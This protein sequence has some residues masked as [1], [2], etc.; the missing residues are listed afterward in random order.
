MK[1]KVSN[2]AKRSFIAE[3]LRINVMTLLNWNSLEYGNF[4]FEQGLLYLE[5]YLSDYN[6]HIQ[7]EWV[8]KLSASPVFWTWWKNH[9]TLRDEQFFNEFSPFGARN[10]YLFEYKKIH[11]GMALASSIQPNR[12]ILEESYPYMISNL[13]MDEQ[14]K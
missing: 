3:S 9:W 14:L 10:G 12:T 6:D 1:T 11:D 4:K 7:K 5:T 13:I 8:S 2:A